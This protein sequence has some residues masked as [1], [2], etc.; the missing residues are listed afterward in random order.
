MSDVK[1]IAEIGGTTLAPKHR[2]QFE[3][4]HSLLLPLNKEVLILPN[5]AVA[6]I[7]PYSEADQVN[8]APQWFLGQLSWR[9]RRI[10]FIS[11]ELA[12]DGEAGKIH[13]HCR[14]AVLNTLNGNS[15]LPYIAVLSQGLP[16]LQLVR[17]N[18]I[19]YADSAIVQR[20][21]IKAYVNLN[22]IAAI[23]PDIDDLE[24]RILGLHD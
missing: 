1:D 6:E 5:A 7:V 4:V 3:A 24:S 2:K 16:S 21:S 23:V 10:P 8:D 14:I 22:G 15:K 13:K 17:P 9:E 11:F 20:Q 18:N 12:S 19:Q